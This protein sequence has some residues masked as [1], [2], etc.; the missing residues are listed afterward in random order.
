M[1]GFLDSSSAVDVR[2][3]AVMTATSRPLGIIQLLRLLLEDEEEDEE[4][5]QCLNFY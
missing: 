5:K 3:F 4:N 2:R 1:H